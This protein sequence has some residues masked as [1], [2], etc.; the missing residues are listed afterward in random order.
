MS[1]LTTIIF[2]FGILI[3]TG[4]FEIVEEVEIEKNG[5]G[6][7][8]YIVNMSQSREKIKTILSLDS[9][10]G[11]RIP[12]QSDIKE[13]LNKGKSIIASVKGIHEVKVEENYDQFIFRISFQFDSLQSLNQAA[14]LLHTE[15]SPYGKSFRQIFVQQPDGFIRNPDAHTTAFLQ[16]LRNRNPAILKDATYTTIYR[17]HQTVNSTDKNAKIAGNHQAVMYRNNIMQLAQNPDLLKHHIIV[18]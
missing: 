18:P 1:R 5:S 13:Q 4:C 7:F 14:E 3:L 16:N 2:L 9:A 8:S 17:F 11:L 6:K 10:G 15:M 12:K